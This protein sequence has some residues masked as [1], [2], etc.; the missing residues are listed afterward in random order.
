M[1]C[2]KNLIVKKVFI[3]LIVL[4]NFLINMCFGAVVSDNDGSAFITKAEYDSLKNTFQSQLDNYN[5]GI[6]SK[7]DSAISS[8]LAGI[9]INKEGKFENRYAQWDCGSNFVWGNNVGLRASKILGGAYTEMKV[10]DLRRGGSSK[11]TYNND[12]TETIF[13]AKNSDNIVYLKPRLYDLKYYEYDLVSY[14]QNAYQT[15]NNM[16]ALS[17]QRDTFNSVS[18]DGS[19][20]TTNAHNYSYPEIMVYDLYAVE[21]ISNSNDNSILS[22]NRTSN[23]FFIREDGDETATIELNEQVSTRETQTG[24]FP[25]AGNQ[26][27]V[28]TIS[29]SW[30]KQL[31]H[32][33]LIIYEW[34][35]LTGYNEY[36]GTGAPTAFVTEDDCKAIITFDTSCGGTV[37][38][39]SN[40]TP[41][42]SFNDSDDFATILSISSATTGG[43]LEIDKCSKGD[44]IRT[45][46]IPTSGTGTMTISDIA[47]KK[48][49]S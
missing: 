18:R 17:R 32:N 19:I 24:T 11:L 35:E 41:L 15:G 9:S 6:D 7:I 25:I 42:T 36:I 28:K 20:K 4:N 46:F 13:I 44:Y 43:K 3:L 2:M 39:Y 38:A 1:F 47:Y 49:S 16:T 8:Y 45:F 12:Y 26:T 29:P 21:N 10:H 22:P 14:A 31:A 48:E 34:K 37:Y 27:I 33:S 40:I 30:Q 5:N 23:E